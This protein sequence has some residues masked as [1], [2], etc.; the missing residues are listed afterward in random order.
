[1]H[2]SQLVSMYPELMMTPTGWSCLLLMRVLRCLLLGAS[3]CPLLRLL[4][5]DD[6]RS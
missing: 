5:D 3:G 2:L 6:L 1:M 4:C